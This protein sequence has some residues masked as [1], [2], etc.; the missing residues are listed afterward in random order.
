[1]YL[2]QILGL[3]FVLSFIGLSYAGEG[4]LVLTDSDFSSR[5]ADFDTS[6]VMFFAPWCGHCKRLKPEFDKAAETLVKD[7]PPIQLVKVDCTEEGKD[8][9]SKYEVRGYPTLKI[10]KNGEVNAEYNGPREAAGIIKYMRAQAGPAAKELKSDSDIKSFI[11]KDESVVVGFFEEE[12]KLK[13]VFLKLADKL[14]ENVMFGHSSNA[15]VL[16]RYGYKDNVV[17]FRA[18]HLQSKFEPDY[19][20][21]EG[22][23][24]KTDLNNWIESNYHGLCGHRNN[25]NA[26]Q[27][28][29]PLVVAY[30]TVDYVKNAKGTNYWRNRIMKIAQNYKDDFTFAISDKDDFQQELNEFGFDYVTGDKP[31]IAARNAQNLKFVMKEEFSM[32]AFDQFLKDLK[33]GKLEPHIKSE[34][35]P[36]QDGPV[37][38]AVAKNFDDVILKSGKDVLIEFY[39]P[40]CGHCKKL[41]PIFDEL[42]A[43]M[44]GEDVVIAKFDATANDVPTG[45]DVSGFPTLFWMPK[46]GKPVQY[47]GGRDLD[48]F[49][50]YIAENAS[51]ELKSYDRDGKV[52]PNKEEL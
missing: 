1:M 50:K 26:A 39:A 29:A 37:T 23:A 47:R 16:S 4:A 33:E 12:S 35:V 28:K 20:V 13:E 24:D 8:T 34:P 27:F 51:T 30:Y 15:D 10:F 38:V 7:D 46:G 36:T 6:L 17:L 21:Y 43:K 3:S 14:R 11:N 32:E 25:D 19:L 22:P 49:I 52:K 2:R 5:M 44:K 31:K 9:C 40:W 18:K 48:D 41:A 45:F 42:G